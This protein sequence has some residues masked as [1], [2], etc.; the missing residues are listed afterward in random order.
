[1][2]EKEGETSEVFERKKG[3]GWVAGGNVKLFNNFRSHS[4]A[5]GNFGEKKSL[6][7]T[8]KGLREKGSGPS[9]KSV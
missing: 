2:K 3:G 8:Q 1:M 9:G 6:P 7:Y 5:Q 4:L